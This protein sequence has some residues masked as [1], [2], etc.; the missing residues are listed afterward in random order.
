MSPLLDTIL[1]ASRS[2]LSMDAISDPYGQDFEG[3]FT[4]EWTGIVS[5]GR[6]I[7]LNVSGNKAFVGVVVD[8]SDG[9]PVAPPGYLLFRLVDKGSPGVG[10][11]TLTFGGGGGRP[12]CP[13]LGSFPDENTPPIKAGEITI[14]DTR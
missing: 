10:R 5:S 7:C 1:T 12:F 3:S 4:L 6:V 13:A 8:V 2:N 14:T 9:A 11:D